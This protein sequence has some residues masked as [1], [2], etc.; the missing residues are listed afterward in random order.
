MKEIKNLGNVNTVNYDGTALNLVED[1][2]GMNLSP[3][4]CACFGCDTPILKGKHFSLEFT[5]CSIC[6][7]STCLYRKQF[8]F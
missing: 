7:P 1:D 4:S 6:T 3:Q 5:K 8:Y 2:V